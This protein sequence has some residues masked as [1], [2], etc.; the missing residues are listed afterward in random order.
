[1]LRSERQAKILE[2]IR[3]KGFIHNEALA[4]TLKVSTVTIR[5]DLKELDKQKLIKLE[6]GGATSIDYLE[7]IPEP[8]YETKMFVNALQKQAIA[9]EALKEIKDGESIIIDSG[10]TCLNLAKLLKREK[11]NKLTVITNDIMVARELGPNS[12]ITIIILGGILRKQYYNAYGPFTELI[13]SNLRAN[14]YFFAFDGF[15]ASRGFSNTV[16]EEIPIKQK[17]IEI[18]DQ[19]I[20][21]C[22]SS[23]FGL[24]APYIICG[25]EKIQKII[26]NEGM[27][28]NQRDV[29]SNKGV[30][31]DIVEVQPNPK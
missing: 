17:M 23:K 3:Q 18:S 29:F 30:A 8:Q 22:D 31:V 9:K 4:L 19:V 5:R 11:F 21:L 14:K 1:M 10:T 7:G 15:T 13:L 2:L 12:N 28:K 20:A 26:T 24:G 16:L 25:L 27:D 6:H